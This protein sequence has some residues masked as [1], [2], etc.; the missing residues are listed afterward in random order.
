MFPKAGASFHGVII[1][2]EAVSAA[3]ADPT[4]NN[5]VTSQFPEKNALPSGRAPPAS[6]PMFGMCTLPSTPRGQ[7]CFTLCKRVV[8][9]GVGRS[10]RRNAVTVC[11]LMRLDVM[12]FEIPLMSQTSG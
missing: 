10:P 4:N 6:C 11:G 9:R 5:R 3:D 2:G 8:F 1:C 7:S 12:A